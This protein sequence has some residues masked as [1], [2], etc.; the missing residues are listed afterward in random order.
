MKIVVGVRCSPAGITD[1]DNDFIVNL[2]YAFDSP[3]EN[4][5]PESVRDVLTT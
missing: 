2:E 3:T 4:S 1:S 5:V